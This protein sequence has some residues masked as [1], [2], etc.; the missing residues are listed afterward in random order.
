MNPSP[1]TS[2]LAYFKGRSSLESA[3][4]QRIGLKEQAMANVPI[5]QSSDSFTTR[6]SKQS[7]AA[8]G[9]NSDSVATS[10]SPGEPGY[11]IK[12]A[13]HENLA[14]HNSS[15]LSPRTNP[16]NKVATAQ[17]AQISPVLGLAAQR[18]PASMSPA[19]KQVPVNFQV[20]ER[21]LFSRILITFARSCTW[22]AGLL[23]Y[24][25]KTTY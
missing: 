3:C 7:S 18:S 15:T 25:R 14:S 16:E 21:L 11:K 5:E 23:P 2:K 12:R 13:F 19:D 4:Q 22:K 8:S 9:L 20:A 1:N 10:I 17:I 24:T 6:D